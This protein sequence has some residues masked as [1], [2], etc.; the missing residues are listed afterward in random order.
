[1]G[2]RK[3]AD[4]PSVRLTASPGHWLPRHPQYYLPARGHALAGFLPRS[5]NDPSPLH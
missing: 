1:M 4:G 2:M 3:K 5:S